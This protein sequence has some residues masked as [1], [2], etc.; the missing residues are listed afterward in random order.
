MNSTTSKPSKP[1][2]PA[3]IQPTSSDGN[4]TSIDT[5]D[6]TSTAVNSSMDLSILESED[7]HCF[8]D[9]NN[10]VNIHKC[11]ALQRMLHA[12]TSVQQN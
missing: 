1:A 9:D 3:T 6:S 4:T 11:A 7:D 12:L 2:T 10:G 5:V 8:T